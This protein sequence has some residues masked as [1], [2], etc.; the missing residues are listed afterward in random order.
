MRETNSQFVDRTLEVW[1]PRTSRA[2]TNDDAHQITENIIGFFTILME[3]EA[4]EKH[5]TNEIT[6]SE[7]PLRHRLIEKRLK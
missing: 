5:A 7:S 6:K 2:L 3:W 4:I 1:K